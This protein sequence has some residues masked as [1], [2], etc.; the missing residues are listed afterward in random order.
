MGVQAQA[1]PAPGW[2]M[3]NSARVPKTSAAM[4]TQGRQRREGKP[5]ATPAVRSR[6]RPGAE[7][8]ERQQGAWLLG[9]EGGGEVG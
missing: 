6:S 8:T 2:E 9:E 1:L 7:A 5:G 3:C 4:E